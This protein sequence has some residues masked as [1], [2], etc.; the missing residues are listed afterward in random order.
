[1]IVVGYYLRIS[2]KNSKQQLKGT[3][4]EAVQLANLK[5]AQTVTI[6]LPPFIDTHQPQNLPLLQGYLKAKLSN[7]KITPGQNFVALFKGQ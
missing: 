5:A 2:K 7:K 1:M 4:D 3:S 6:I